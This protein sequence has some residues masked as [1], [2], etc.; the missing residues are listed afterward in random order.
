MPKDSTDVQCE[1][2]NTKSII[3]K[4]SFQQL[5]LKKKTFINYLNNYYLLEYY[6]VWLR[7]KLTMWFYKITKIDIYW[8]NIYYSNKSKSK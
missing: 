3:S 7:L 2:L 5:H 6:Y 1:T 8:I 4:Q